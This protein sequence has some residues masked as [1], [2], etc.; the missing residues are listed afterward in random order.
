MQSRVVA[1]DASNHF[2]AAVVAKAPLEVCKELHRYSLRKP[3]WNKLLPPGKAWERAHGLLSPDEE[4]PEGVEAYKTNPLWETAAECLSYQL[5]YSQRVERPRH[6][7]V[8]EVRAML[9][10]ERTLGR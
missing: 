6:I 9:R 7:N 4:V 8:G 5:L 3:V 10:A 1:T 2:E